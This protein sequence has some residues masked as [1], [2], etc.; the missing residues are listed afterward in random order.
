MIIHHMADGSIRKSVEGFIIPKSFE[1]VYELA[2]K[3]REIV[4]D[5]TSRTIREK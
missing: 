5:S 3:K 4:D 1:K 2:N